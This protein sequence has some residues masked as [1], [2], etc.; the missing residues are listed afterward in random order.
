MHERTQ[1]QPLKRLA[2][3]CDRNGSTMVEIEFD[4]SVHD[5]DQIMTID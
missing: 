4:N 3:N 1:G 5:D 2:D